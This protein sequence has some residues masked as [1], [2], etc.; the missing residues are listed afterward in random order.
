[1]G[2]CTDICVIDT[3]L[4]LLSARNHDMVPSLRDIHVYDQGCATFDLPRALAEELDPG[5][6]AAH[7]QDATHH[8]GLYFMA[9]RGAHLV[10][11]V[12]I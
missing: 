1:M 10:D 11:K 3:V 5:I 6:A 9:A 4:T 8:M 12:E 7:P 2:F